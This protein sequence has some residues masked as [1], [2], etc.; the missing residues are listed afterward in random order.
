MK[1]RSGVLK[2]EAAGLQRARFIREEAVRDAREREEPLVLI[3]VRF[4]AMLHLRDPDRVF[5]HARMRTR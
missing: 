5:R 3:P 4:F 2:R 1:V